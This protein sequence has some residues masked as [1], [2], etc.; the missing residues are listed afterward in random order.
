MDQTHILCELLNRMSQNGT[1]QTEPSGQM[2]FF[3]LKC[4]KKHLNEFSSL[5]NGEISHKTS[6]LA[7]LVVPFYKATVDCSIKAI[8][9]GLEGLLPSFITQMQ[10]LVLCCLT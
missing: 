10:L 4:L 6:D 3:W 9:Q 7:T 2:C 8:F 1:Q 5:E